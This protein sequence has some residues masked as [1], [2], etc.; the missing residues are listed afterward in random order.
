MPVDMTQLPKPLPAPKKWNIWCWALLL[1]ALIVTGSL[2]TFILSFFYAVSNLLFILGA[3][4]LPVSLWVFS[5]LYGLYHRG[6]REAYV[7][8]WNVH[9]ESRRQQLIDYARRGLY[10]LQN[11]LITEYGD[12]GNADGVVSGQYAI[13]AKCPSSGG[14]PVPHS[15]LVLPHNVSSSYFYE[16][17]QAIFEQWYLECKER[18][19]VLPSDLVIHVRL[20]IDT[21]AK[22]DNLETLWLKTLGKIIH[23]TSFSIEETESS[24][25]FIEQWLDNS[26]HDDDLL[27]IISTHLFSSPQKNEAESALLMLFAGE[28]AI[29]TLPLADK[30]TQ[31][32][33]VYRSEQT[34]NLNKSIDNA[35]LWGADNDKAYDGVWYTGVSP[36]QNI[37]IMNHFNEIE[38]APGSIF[39]IDTS[40]GY[41]GHSAYWLALALAIEQ[42][43][44]TN[45]RQLIVCGKPDITASVVASVTRE[46][47]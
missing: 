18:L 12:G 26:D 19:S 10:V 31:L 46:Q 30:Q 28:Q 44:Q 41:A 23:P 11:S 33:K 17:L 15:A 36:E 22:L 7:K 32:T 2:I 1:V 42:T 45:N 13:T 25:I 35:L 20:F 16:R 29:K 4:I 27:L 9:L 14:S 40:I 5:T 3:V 37:E 6:Y 8:E 39:N 47:Q 21:P 34:D 43:Q 38:F 24:A